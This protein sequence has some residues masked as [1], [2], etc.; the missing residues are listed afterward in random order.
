VGQLLPGAERGCSGGV[1]RE[2]TRNVLPVED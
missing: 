1:Y 2:K